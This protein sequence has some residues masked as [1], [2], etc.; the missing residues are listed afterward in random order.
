MDSLLNLRYRQMAVDNDALLSPVGQV[1]RYLR[2]N[3]PEINLYTGDGSH[4]SAAGSYT[5]ALSFYTVMFRKDPATIP[6][7]HTLT[8]EDAATIKSAVQTVV[9]D[10]LLE[11]HVGEY[12][13]SADFSVTLVDGITYSFVSEA[14][15]ALSQYWSMNGSTEA[16][17]TY[18]FPA[19]GTYEVELYT[20]NGCDSLSSIQVVEVMDSTTGLAEFELNLNNPVRGVLS[21]PAA[22]DGYSL[23]IL[24]YNGQVVQEVGRGHGRT[25]QLNA[26]PTGIYIL[27][28]TNSNGGILIDTF[29]KD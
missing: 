17:T 21:L 22:L 26:L 18:T 19:T 12:D 10:N 15:N 16:T 3:H 24:N 27:K 11:W 4:P 14:S 28:G 2:E 9:Y 1:W 8:A 5:A 20:S 6:F 29:F 13:L 7:N 25:F 23:S